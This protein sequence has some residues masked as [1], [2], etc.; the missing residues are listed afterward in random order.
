M[1]R[2]VYRAVKPDSRYQS[3]NDVRQDL[4]AIYQDITGS[5]FIPASKEEM[6]LTGVRYK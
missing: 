5:P 6:D 2:W 3:F 4:A 1:K